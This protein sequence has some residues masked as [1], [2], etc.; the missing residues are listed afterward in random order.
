MR[1]RH[2][3]ELQWLGFGQRGQRQEV[4][5]C[6]TIKETI[7]KEQKWHIVGAGEWGKGREEEISLD[8]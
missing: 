5:K 2:E 1:A 6:E 8:M 3:S 7:K 4:A